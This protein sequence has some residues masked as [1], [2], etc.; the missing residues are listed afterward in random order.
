M[1]EQS[2]KIL[3]A[4]YGRLIALDTSLRQGTRH[5]VQLYLAL[6][7]AGVA[8][9]L[10]GL[11]RTSPGPFPWDTIAI[12]MLPSVLGL[13]LM[14]F[15]WLVSIEVQIMQVMSGLQTIRD[16]F[17]RADPTIKEAFCLI[18]Q[19]RTSTHTRNGPHGLG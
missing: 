12:I 13:G 14:S 3:L 2:I 9:I 11:V 6:I 19:S 18:R 17:M 4:E 15:L 1:E 7:T 10:S 5:V 8:A 16:Y